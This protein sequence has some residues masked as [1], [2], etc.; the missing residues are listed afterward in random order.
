MLKA[1]KIYIIIT[2]TGEQVCYYITGFQKRC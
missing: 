2:G 1:A